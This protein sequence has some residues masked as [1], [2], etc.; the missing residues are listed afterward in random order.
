MARWKGGINNPK[1]Q[2]LIQAIK[3][4]LGSESPS[5]IFAPKGG[6]ELVWIPGG[7]F[8]MGSPDSEKDHEDCEGPQHTVRVPDF[9]MGRYPVTNEEYGRFLPDNPATPEPVWWEDSE[10]GKPRQPV[11][12]V[13][14]ED[15]Q[16]YARWAG[17]QLPSEAQWEYACRACTK[18]RYY[19]GD[20]EEDLDRVG[21][22]ED[23]SDLGPHPV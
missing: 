22:Y 23:N 17:L 10:F 6:Y 18:T 4:V 20:T 1:Y 8:L 19:S 5:V 21:W 7:E 11:V 12:S 9:Y 16:Q 2:Q 15:A 14:W 13:S 3:E